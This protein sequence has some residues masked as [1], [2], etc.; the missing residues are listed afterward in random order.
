MRLAA[1]E[2]N[3]GLSRPQTLKNS[4]YR[5][6]VTV[7]VNETVTGDGGVET[8]DRAAIGLDG[9]GNGDGGVETHTV[10]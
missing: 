6:T 5:S 10:E 9:D 4:A 7:A 2:P 8:D 1:F 3:F